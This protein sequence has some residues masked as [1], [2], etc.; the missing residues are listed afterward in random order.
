LDAEEKR[1][2]MIDFV[3]RSFRD[4]ADRDYVAARVLYAQGLGPQFLWAAHQAIEK[5]LKAILLYSDVSTRDLGHDLEKAL[6]RLASIRDIRFDLPDDVRQFVA[7]LNAEGPNR[8]FE[9]P[10]ETTGEELLSLDRAVWH[11]RRYC[12][13]MRGTELS[14][15]GPTPRLPGQL[16]YV[17]SFGQR[18]VHAFAIPGGGFLERTLRQ[19]ESPLR[20]SLVW[21]NFY[22]GSYK[23]RA[24]KRF[25][26]QSWSANPTH[27]LDPEIFP[28]LSRLVRF[29]KAVEHAFRQRGIS[30]PAP[31]RERRLPFE[32][33]VAAA[34][35]EST[36]ALLTRID[37]L[38]ERALAI[39]GE[40]GVTI[41]KTRGVKPLVINVV[42][43]LYAKAC[44]TLR[45]VRMLGAGGFAEDA[46]VLA[47][48]L[49]ETA[50]AV[51]WILQS[52]SLRR[53]QMYIA[54]MLLRDEQLLAEW[55]KTPGLKRW[56]TKKRVAT[57]RAR[58]AVYEARLGSDVIASLRRSWSGRTLEQTAKAVGVQRVY[59]VFYRRASRP[60]HAA[61]LPQHLAFAPD[62]VTVLKIG[63]GDFEALE[64]VLRM[65][66]LSFWLLL[67][68]VDRRF[69][70]GHDS[71]LE[72]LGSARG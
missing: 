40:G 71:D 34:V 6:D 10:A 70:L 11:L 54:H 59:Q 58:L 26:L 46:F 44:K 55:K 7:Y 41:T 48:T 56:A 24:I 50:V 69:G 22:Y 18:Q 66:Y 13:W 5:Y 42:F 29:S 49:F 38:L 16:K 2:L 43:G 45:T 21:K 27:Y 30:T 47:R 3:N 17:H 52:A 67:R 57:A 15:E 20:R 65:S 51:R 36:S 39:V 61:D 53:S 19:R 64:E 4:M 37:R 62:K 63:P 28:E 25:R 12:Y 31:V 32:S 68:R 35:P 33:E 9:Y 72:A 14:P 8:Y 1:A 60:G 23:K